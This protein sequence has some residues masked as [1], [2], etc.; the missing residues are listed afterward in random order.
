MADEN[1]SK[2]LVDAAF[3]K[4]EA[5]EADKIKEENKANEGDIIT[6]KRD[7]QQLEA[8][9]TSTNPANSVV[10]DLT[11]ME[12]FHERNFDFEKTVVAHK[13]Y[14]IKKRSKK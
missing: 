2:G 8:V 5:E 10:C 9:V 11:I 3:N 13:N 4:K 14:T 1:L 7:G 6:F 12:D